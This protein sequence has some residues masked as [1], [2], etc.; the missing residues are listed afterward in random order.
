MMVV[1][2]KDKSMHE[3]GNVYTKYRPSVLA[4]D[5]IQVG[6]DVVVVV[7]DYSEKAV[8]TGRLWRRRVEEKV[9]PVVAVAIT[10]YHDKL[11]PA[12]NQV[13]AVAV[14]LYYSK[15]KPHLDK[16]LAKAQP[17][18]DQVVGAVEKHR[19]KVVVTTRKAYRDTRG[20]V[21]EVLTTH[22]QLAPY[23]A[24]RADDIINV[25]IYILLALVA[26]VFRRLIFFLLLLPLRLL[27]WFIS[28]PFRSRGRS[29]SATAG[30]SNTTAK[31]KKKLTPKAT[32]PKSGTEAVPAAARAGKT[33]PPTPR[34][35]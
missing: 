19:V 6:N 17:H 31:G 12:Y 20:R 8:V 26:L 16:L 13:V 30:S 3:L 2:D 25:S 23:T 18:I 34:K 5:A 27:W 32:H 28:Y 35:A 24:D 14:P 22:P 9:A 33:K 4:R 21:R 11:K 1:D 10:I 7:R 29:D 15:V